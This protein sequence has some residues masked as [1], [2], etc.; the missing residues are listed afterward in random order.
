[1]ILMFLHCFDE[2]KKKKIPSNNLLQF[3]E[4][5][6][7]GYE[8]FAND[9]YIMILWLLAPSKQEIFLNPS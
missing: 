3:I 6:F 4:F 5:I 9:L 2:R 1:M 7:H 8:E